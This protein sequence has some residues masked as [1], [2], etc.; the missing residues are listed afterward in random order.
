MVKEL[1]EKYP[2][3]LLLDIAGLSKQSYYYVVKH[4]NDKDNKDKLYEDLI[5]KIFK[6]NYQKY[7][8]LR[9]TDALNIEL[10]KNHFPKINHKRVERLMR[11]LVSKLDQNK[12]NTFPLKVILERNV[13]TFF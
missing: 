9:I 3:H 12:E 7:G 2:F 10:E 4:Y 5:I 6:K 8:I 1:R 11:K 13:R